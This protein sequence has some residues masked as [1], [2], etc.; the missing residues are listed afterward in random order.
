MNI[1]TLRAI[2]VNSVNMVISLLEFVTAVGSLREVEG[3]KKRK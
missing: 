1:R 2:R 3:G